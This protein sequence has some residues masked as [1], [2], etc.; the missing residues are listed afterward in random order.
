M[1][2][3]KLRSNLW[4]AET[5][6]RGLESARDQSSTLMDVGAWDD[7]ALYKELQDPLGFPVD[8]QGIK[9]F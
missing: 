5:L 6:N 2:P 1:E 9:W 3:A 7:E 8:G 4:S